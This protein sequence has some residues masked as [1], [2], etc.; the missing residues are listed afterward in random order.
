MFIEI[1]RWL[2]GKESACQCRRV[3]RHRFDPWVG[4]IPWRRKWLPSPVLLPRK[5]HEQRHLVGY[6]L[7]GF[8]EPDMTE[9]VHTHTHTQWCIILEGSA[10][11]FFFHKIFFVGKIATTL[12]R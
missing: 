2:S 7:W 6:S 8:K 4:K 5:S 11:I 12:K 1:P 9:H 10:F 3:R